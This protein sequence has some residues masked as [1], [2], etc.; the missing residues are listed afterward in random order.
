[1]DPGAGPDLGSQTEG[2]KVGERVVTAAIPA[3]PEPPV[4]G[5]W[6]VHGFRL[7]RWFGNAS[8]EDALHAPA[9]VRGLVADEVLSIPRPGRSRSKP[10]QKPSRYPKHPHTA[11]SLGA[12]R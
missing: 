10:S 7:D 9:Q 11:P 5:T 6:Q 8:P 12:R 1:M 4:A 2:L 3:V